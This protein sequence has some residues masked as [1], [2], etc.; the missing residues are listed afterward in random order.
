VVNEVLQWIVLVVL[1]LFLLGVLR[2][3]S[4]LLP[5]S[6]RTSE[7]GPVVGTRLGRRALDRIQRA[8]PG[9]RLESGLALVFVTE[10]CTGCQRLLADM[11]RRF[12]NG[13]AANVEAAPIIVAE[14][15]SD[16]FRGAL[17]RLGLPIVWDDGTIWKACNVTAT[18]LVVTADRNGEV[19]SKEVTHSAEFHV[20]TVTAHQS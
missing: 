13:N 14:S 10:S 16:G 8:L 9:G 12:G 7:G 6:A 18:P 5:V 15:G 1:T 2:Q 4:L 19:L 3:L 17:E 20:E 11:E